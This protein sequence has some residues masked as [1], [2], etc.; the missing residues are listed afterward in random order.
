[1][2][3]RKVIFLILLVSLTA[4]S[5]AES[6]QASV[7]NKDQGTIV[8]PQEMKKAIEAFNPDFEMWKLED[9]APQ[10]VNDDHQKDN[11]KKLP[12]ALIVDANKDNT[13]DVIL[14][15]HDKKKAF[16][17]GVISEKDEY[18]VLLIEE[19]KL[20]SPGTIENMFEGKKEYGLSY[21]LWTL[22]T[23]KEIKEKNEIFMIGYPQ[24]TTADGELLND[25]SFITYRYFNG[26][27]EAEYLAL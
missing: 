8:L 20:V 21:F 16:L 13:P 1:M 4:C 23:S 5:F 24:Q 11:R 14:D 26:K 22:E 7:I 2:K 25:G 17:I 6:N 19:K 18:R 27:F 3:I 10:V 9:Y 15:G 12:F